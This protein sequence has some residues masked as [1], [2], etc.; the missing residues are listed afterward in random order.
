MTIRFLKF[1]VF[2]LLYSCNTTYH[3]GTL[4]YTDYPVEAKNPSDST[5]GKYLEPFRDSMDIIMNEVVGTVAQRMDVKRPVTTL[6]NFLSDAY[7][8]MARAKYDPKADFAVMN[9]GGIRRPYIEAGPLT[10]GA[11]FEVMPFDNLMVLVTVKGVLLKKF[12]N[13]MAAEGGGVAG[14][15]M[16][17]INKKADKIL[18]N[19]KDLDEQSLYTMVTSDYAANNPMMQWFYGSG[20]RTDTNYLLRDAIIDYAQVMKKSGS[21]IGYQL[22]NRLTIVN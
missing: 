7:L 18:I 4:R 8:I 3:P 11:V 21:P 1:F 5:F 15:N 10:R 6:G 9:L 16:T 17:I 22:E 13:E 19:G 12:L 14:M 20:K 2:F